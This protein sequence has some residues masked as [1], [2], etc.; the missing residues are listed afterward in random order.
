MPGVTIMD[1][2][3]VDI[4]DPTKKGHEHTGLVIAT[5]L[6]I[7]SREDFTRSAAVAGGRPKQGFGD[8]HKQRRRY[9]LTGDVA[10]GK[11]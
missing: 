10:D 8:G 4:Q 7:Q 3:G 1:L 2:A 9:S 6:G 5:D 11:T